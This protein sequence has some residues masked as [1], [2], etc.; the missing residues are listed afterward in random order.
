MLRLSLLIT[1]AALVATRDQMLENKTQTQAH[2]CPPEEEEAHLERQ[3]F[4]IHAAVL[5]FLM[6]LLLTSL[7]VYVL[8]LK[9]RPLHPLASRPSTKEAA[10]PPK[11]SSRRHE[12]GRESPRRQRKASL[13]SLMI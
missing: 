1:A 10:T 8:F 4:L 9:T 13:S 3:S 2:T 7:A 6:T 11:G 12:E 5:V